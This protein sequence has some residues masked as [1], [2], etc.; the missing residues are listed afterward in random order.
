MQL[1][2]APTCRPHR[3][4]FIA[5]Q[6]PHSFKITASGLPGCNALQRAPPGQ[7]VR[8]ECRPAA[9]AAISVVRIRA[10]RITGRLST[11]LMQLQTYAPCS[12]PTT[13]ALPVSCPARNN[14]RVGDV[15]TASRVPL[16]RFPPIPST[17]GFPSVLPAHSSGSMT[18]CI[19]NDHCNRVELQL[20]K[21]GT[22]MML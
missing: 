14:S 10:A 12:H 7:P 16:T 6:L 21:T 5:T 4:H 19:H 1:T 3:P 22:T 18:C 9:A 2:P 13:S 8:R 17:R 11:Y 15:L 20:K